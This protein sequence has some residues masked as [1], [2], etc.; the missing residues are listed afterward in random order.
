M[1]DNRVLSQ[2]EIDTMLAGLPLQQVNQAGAAPTG[3]SFAPMLQPP[4]IAKPVDPVSSQPMPLQVARADPATP[5]PARSAAPLVSPLTDIPQASAP[6]VEDWD[7]G[8]NLPVK[9]QL[10]PP[11]ED[12][13]GDSPQATIVVT[14]EH[15][16]KME[17]AFRKIERL[18]KDL[19]DQKAEVKEMRTKL[20][21]TL[22]YGA[23][24]SFTCASCKAQGFV[25][26]RLTCTS[27][28]THNR[29]A[30]LPKKEV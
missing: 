28:G 30:W 26:L 2:E 14:R 7:T 25:S 24:H 20:Q 22:G 6:E 12:P 15:L 19:L 17:A 13:K 18:E 1:Q 27:C 5:T 11:V 23:R 16:N 4:P 8:Q 3:S 10:V 9:K 29:L 21:G